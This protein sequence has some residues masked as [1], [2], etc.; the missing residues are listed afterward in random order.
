MSVW[1]LIDQHRNSR[2]MRKRCVISMRV[3]V[4][5]RVIRLYRDF[6]VIAISRNLLS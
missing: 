4:D 5:L 2:L 1:S 3:A 6:V